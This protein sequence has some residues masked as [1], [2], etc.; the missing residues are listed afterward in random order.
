MEE[1]KY[2]A[3][4]ARL[5][6]A[7]R[8]T[9]ED[10]RS[11]MAILRSPEGCAW[12]REQTH[13][14]IRACLL[15]EAYEAAEGIDLADDTLLCEELGDLL[16]QVIFHSAIAEERQAFGYEDIVSGVCKKLILRHPHVFGSET[17]VSS[18]EMIEKWEA[19]KAE[20][21][22]RD[23]LYEDMNSVAKTLPA[24][25]RAQK[26][27]K[28]AEKGGM[29]IPVAEPMDAQTLAQ[30]LFSLCAMA[31]KQGLDAENLLT[32]YNNRLVKEAEEV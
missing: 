16:L 2:L 13:A 4:K 19:I 7:K 32:G 30:T 8:Y 15:E 12:D 1:K 18:A 10:L 6:S 31:Q 29:Q 24:L 26:L 14:S 9:T 5:A 17:A 28:K 22:H 3:E 27:A 11:I 20:T 21:K 23:T 25:V